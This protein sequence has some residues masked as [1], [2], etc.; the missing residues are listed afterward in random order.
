MG[1]AKPGSLKD[2]KNKFAKVDAKFKKIGKVL[3]CPVT[4]GKSFKN[5]NMSKNPVYLWTCDLIINIIWAFIY[6]WMLIFVYCPV[7]LVSVILYYALRSFIPNLRIIKPADICPS[8]RTFKQYANIY[9]WL[10]RSKKTMAAAYCM[11]PIPLILQPL[12]KESTFWSGVSNVLSGSSV[13]AM[14]AVTCLL[15]AGLYFI[16]ISATTI[17]TKN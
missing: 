8:L 1:K 12:T 7:G 5:K 16:R 10:Y 6:L 14:I 11:E 2:T 9:N 17:D 13:M 4:L 15:L 3:A